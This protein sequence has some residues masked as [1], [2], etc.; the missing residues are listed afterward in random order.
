MVLVIY[1]PK[2]AYRGVCQTID[3]E[4]TSAISFFGSSAC[5]WLIPG[6]ED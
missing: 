4:L 2:T 6:S 3:T 5:V 1:F